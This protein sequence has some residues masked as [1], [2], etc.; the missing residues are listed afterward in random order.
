MK[1]PTKRQIRSW[2]KWLAGR[3]QAVREVAERMPPWQLLSMNGTG[4]IVSAVSYNENGTV[5][6][7]VHHDPRPVS[8]AG[9][10]V[11]GVDPATLSPAN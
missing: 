1:K 10:E 4:Q 11:F 3:P 9:F 8:F 2:N 6:V 5:T 7:H